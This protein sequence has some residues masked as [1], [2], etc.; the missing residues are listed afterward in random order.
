VGRHVLRDINRSFTTLRTCSANL[1]DRTKPKPTEPR[2]GNNEFTAAPSAALR[3]A[4][5]PGRLDK[6]ILCNTSQ[7]RSVFFFVPNGL[8]GNFSMEKPTMCPCIFV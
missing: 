6:T 4:C 3:F 8:F 5:R 1:L 2:V 7:V